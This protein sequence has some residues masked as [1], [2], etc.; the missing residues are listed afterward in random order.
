[1]SVT[2]DRTMFEC[3][4]DIKLAEHIYIYIVVVSFINSCNLLPYISLND[5]LFSGYLIAAILGQ[6]EIYWEK[7]KLVGTWATP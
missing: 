7:L 4:S 2:T 5:T 3:I 1:M 6:L